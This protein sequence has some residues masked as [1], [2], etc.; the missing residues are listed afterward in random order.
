[1][2]KD[3]GARVIEMAFNTHLNLLAILSSDGKFELVKVNINNKESI[4]KKLIRAD[5]RKALK[6]KRDENIDHDLVKNIKVDKELLQ[7]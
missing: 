2:K 7:A 4:L 1:M 3:S 5:K 6:R